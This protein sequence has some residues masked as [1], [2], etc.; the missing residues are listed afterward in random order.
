[1]AGGKTWALI[2]VGVVVVAAGAYFLVDRRADEIA[3]NELTRMFSELPEG[4]TATYAA[5]DIDPTGNS[6]V[7]DDLVVDIDF[8]T[9][10]KENPEAFAEYERE[11]LRALEGLKIRMEVDQWAVESIDTA[12]DPPHY[13][14]SSVSEFRVSF[15][16]LSPDAGAAMAKILS[17]D[18]LTGRGTVA[19]RYD[20]DDAQFALETYDLQLDDILDLRADGRFG[21]IHDW[22]A[23]GANPNLSPNAD[24]ITVE[25]F[26]LSLT[27]RG[28]LERVFEIM[29]EDGEQSAAESRMGVAFMAGLMIASLETPAAESAAEAV[30]EFLNSGGTLTVSVAPDAPVR[31]RDLES[32]DEQDAM[33]VMQRLNITATHR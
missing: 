1:M 24:T 29:A 10:M 18:T 26:E 31:L 28:L 2:G 21:G 33:R 4:Y 27:D 8:D 32:D 25:D 5:V 16:G 20:P 17:G 22:Q 14:D 3:D 7:V 11:D 12:N 15:D 19:Y 9:M 6:G 23:V 30:V 13:V